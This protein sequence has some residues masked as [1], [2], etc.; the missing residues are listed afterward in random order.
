MTYP[1]TGLRFI[2]AS[3]LVGHT[4]LLAAVP[5]SRYAWYRADVGVTVDTGGNI[6]NWADQVVG[7]QDFDHVIGTPGTSTLGRSGGGGVF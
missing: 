4:M 1:F 7:G 6:T 2:V 3:L 5:G